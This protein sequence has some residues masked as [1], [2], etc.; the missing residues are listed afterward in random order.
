MELRQLKTLVAIADFKTFAAAAD[1]VGLTQSAISLQIKALEDELQTTLFDRTRRPPVLNSRGRVL[2]EHARDVLATCAKIKAMGGAEELSGVLDLG[3]VPTCIAGVLPKALASIQKTHP[4][5]RIHVTSAQS[6]E[7]AERLSGGEFDAVALTEP[8]SA[9]EGLDWHPFAREPLVVIAPPQTTGTT[10]KEI[11][12]AGPYIQFSRN[13]WAGQIIARHLDDRAIKVQ[14]GMEID[15][16]EAISSMVAH[17]LGVSVIPRPASEPL[18]PFALRA[19]PFG[20]P[21]Q[22]RVMG[23]LERAGNPKTRLVR[24]LLTE[25]KRSCG[26][27]GFD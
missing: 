16:M 11:L 18:V 26:R 2:V 24:A 27:N 22:Y 3:A 19:F 6:A 10:D 7:L 8:Y 12:E 14:L 1:A 23:L 21:L 13:T 17:G 25:L 5:L 9:I 15:S 4:K 20:D